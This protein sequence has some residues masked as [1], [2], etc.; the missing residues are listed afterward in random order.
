M[1]PYCVV[2]EKDGVTVRK[3]WPGWWSAWLWAIGAALH[4]WTVVARYPIRRPLP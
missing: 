1:T 3:Q 2:I 4:G